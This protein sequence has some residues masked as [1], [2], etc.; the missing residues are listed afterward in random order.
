[1]PS[2]K[3]FVIVYVSERVDAEL[4]N[5][6]EIF[7]RL[8][9][10]LRTDG[11]RDG[12]RVHTF[13]PEWKIPTAV[14]PGQVVADLLEQRTLHSGSYVEDRLGPPLP[15][16]P[17]PVRHRWLLTDELHREVKRGA[18]YHDC[19]VSDYVAR[20]VQPVL[21]H[22]WTK[23]GERLYDHYGIFD[24]GDHGFGLPDW[25]YRISERIFH[26]WKAEE[27]AR[28]EAADKKRP[29]PVPPKMRPNDP[30]SLL[31]VVVGASEAEVKKA[32]RDAVK[33][34]HPDRGG[35]QASFV[36]VSNAYQTLK[37]THGW[38]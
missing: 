28:K 9:H 3:P 2:S 31:G 33:K 12:E 25:A 30:W 34:H 27:R 15:D 36:A 6:A 23:T 21:E 1:M 26:M 24:V 17:R 37:S 13:G 14:A 32:W 29:P 10:Q 11:F 22:R 7:S 19:S 20:I 4:R 38:G 8:A 5:S 35:D 18:A 16:E